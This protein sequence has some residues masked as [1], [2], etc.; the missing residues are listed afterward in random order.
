MFVDEHK[1][2]CDIR[3]ACRNVSS[4]KEFLLQY[5]QV[6]SWRVLVQKSYSEFEISEYNSLN[7]RLNIPESR[8]G[9]SNGKKRSHSVINLTTFDQPVTL[10]S[11]LKFEN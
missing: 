4:G 7:M 10:L 3:S 2:R 9:H 8:S 5:T 1:E 6:L 11:D